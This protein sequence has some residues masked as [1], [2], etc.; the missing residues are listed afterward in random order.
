MPSVFLAQ[1]QTLQRSADS[2]ALLQSAGEYTTQMRLFYI[3]GSHLPWRMAEIQQMKEGEGIDVRRRLHYFKTIERLRTC[4]LERIA[5][6]RA[7]VALVERYNAGF[8]PDSSLDDES[9]EA[10][11]SRLRERMCRV[12]PDETRLLQRVA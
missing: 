1:L 11:R 3:T 4:L 6:F 8:V 7:D 2:Y 5:W 12:K 9:L 10:A